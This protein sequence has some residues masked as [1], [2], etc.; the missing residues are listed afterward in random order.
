MN[1]Y[2]NIRHDISDASFC[3]TTALELL[4]GMAQDGPAQ[5]QAMSDLIAS[6]ERVRDELE[7]LGQKVTEVEHQVPA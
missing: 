4:S 2:D 1:S 6:L 5:N 7:G 3:V